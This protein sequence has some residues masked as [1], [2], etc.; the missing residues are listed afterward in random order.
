MVVIRYAENNSCCNGVRWQSEALCRKIS[1]MKTIAEILKKENSHLAKLIR[2]TKTSQ[3]LEAIFYT[4]IDKSFAKYCRFANYNNS[5]LTIIVANTS[6]ATKLR[7]A[8]PDIIKNLRI[9]PEFKTITA[10][11][12][13]IAATM[14]K[15]MPKNKQSKLSSNNQ[16]LWEKTLADLQK[17][18]KLKKRSHKNI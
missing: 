12:Y 5:T 17:K 8:I 14:P 11:R 6:W 4:I 2:Y 7:Y 16:I 10:I 1:Q 9:Q 18:T 13:S 3:N 15:L